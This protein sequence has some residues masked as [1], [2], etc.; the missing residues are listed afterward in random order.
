MMIMIPLQFLLL[1]LIIVTEVR[2]NLKDA[3]QR[4]HNASIPQLTESGKM[5]LIADI[6]KAK[7]G[8]NIVMIAHLQDLEI[9]SHVNIG[10]NTKIE[11]DKLEH[12]SIEDLKLVHLKDNIPNFYML[13]LSKKDTNAKI[14]GLISIIQ[15][16]DFHAQIS[17]L[18][19]DPVNVEALYKD[20]NIYNIYIFSPDYTAYG[21]PIINDGTDRAIY[22]MF[23]IC[24]FCD[25]GKD[26]LEKVNTWKLNL[27]F[28]QNLQFKLSFTGSFHKNSVKMSIFE[29]LIPAFHIIGVDDNNKKIYD[30]VFYRWYMVMGDILN[31]TWEFL[32]NR[33]GHPADFGTYVR[34]LNDGY[35]DLIGCGWWTTYDRYTQAGGMSQPF[36]IDE[37]VSV[38][39]V[40]P[41]KTIQP[42]AI[43]KA[44]DTSTWVILFSC[45]PV[46]GLALYLSR[47]FAQNTDGNNNNS[48][49]PAFWRSCWDIVVIMCLESLSVKQAPW[50]VLFV[51][52]TYMIAAF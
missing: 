21:S 23:S 12:Q 52:G 18:Y 43:Y 19:E 46:S 42:N 35:V 13:L 17:L 34:D 33:Y 50:A 48:D 22:K 25:D 47:K 37:G 32:P 31:V 49:R 15:D 7:P 11:T 39:S 44:F 30:G 40:E 27:G 45:M 5:K 16:T 36:L 20:R 1:S 3:L 10:V 14:Q 24:R 6:T 26:R 28:V 29:T 9:I 8:N 38:V 2:G 51:F 41:S 4:T